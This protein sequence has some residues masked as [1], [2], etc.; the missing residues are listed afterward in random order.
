V[1]LGGAAVEGDAPAVE[2]QDAGDDLEEGAL[3]G[4]VGPHHGDALAGI[5]RERHVVQRADA[6][7]A[8]HEALSRDAR[9]SG[10]VFVILL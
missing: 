5:D 6:V 2:L 4:A 9:R 3:A 8:H 1:A 7:I 10:V